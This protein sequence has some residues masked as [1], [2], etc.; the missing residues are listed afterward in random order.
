MLA[1]TGGIAAA[2]ADPHR[3]SSVCA[4]PHGPFSSLRPPVQGRCWR[5]APASLESWADDKIEGEVSADGLIVAI[6]TLTLAG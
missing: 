6:G 4:S 3:T 5:R 2:S 1:Q